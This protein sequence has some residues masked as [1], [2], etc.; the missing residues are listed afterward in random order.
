MN[1]ILSQNERFIF[2]ICLSICILLSIKYCWDSLVDPDIKNKLSE[3]I[4]TSSCFYYEK[5]IFLFCIS[6]CIFIMVKHF[7][8]LSTRPVIGNSLSVEVKPSPFLNYKGRGLFATRDYKKGEILE[9]CPA[10]KVTPDLPGDNIIKDYV[11]L[12]RDGSAELLAFGYGS[13][14]NHSTDHAN[15]DWTV[16]NDDQNIE[17]FL[18]KDVKKGEEFLTNYGYN[19]WASRKGTIDEL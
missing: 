5:H 8:Y 6:L 4:N 1:I 16:G 3:K 9:T 11:F 7:W 13:M 10:I 2:L 12:S 15:C 19:Y 17:M 18:V 14:I